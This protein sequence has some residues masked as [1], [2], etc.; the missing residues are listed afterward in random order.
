MAALLAFSQSEFEMPSRRGFAA[1]VL[2][3]RER[4]TTMFRLPIFTWNILVSSILPA[5][6]S[7]A[8]IGT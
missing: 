5:L 6:Y 4:G 7:C 1:T 3:A 8:G 2:E